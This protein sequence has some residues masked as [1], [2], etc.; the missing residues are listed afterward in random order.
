MDYM[1]V[2]YFDQKIIKFMNFARKN[3]KKYETWWTTILGVV[4]GKCICWRSPTN[5]REHQ[6][7]Q[8]PHSMHL[9]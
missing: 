3:D 7:N 8:Q 6:L 1:L 5:P 2:S 9:G 4:R